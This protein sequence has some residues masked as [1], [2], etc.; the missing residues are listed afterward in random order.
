MQV[1]ILFLEDSVSL[2]CINVQGKLILLH[3]RTLVS[4]GDS[5]YIES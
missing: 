4:L 1:K 5:Q 2:Y 3:T